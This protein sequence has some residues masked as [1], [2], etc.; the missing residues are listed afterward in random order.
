M[1]LIDSGYL[2]A[3]AIESDQLHERAVRWAR[4]VRQPLLVSEYVLWET[5]NYLSG[6]AEDRAK[7][8]RVV[9]RVMS[10][11]VCEFLRA[12]SE[13]FDAG[14]KLHRH[15]SD[16][17]WSLTDCI[18]FHLMHEKKDPRRFGL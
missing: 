5:I 18:S 12:T 13:F 9:E 14:M 10:N 8:H 11:P 3:L 7:A 15:R 17:K 4:Q 1:I 2:I 6:S 16:K